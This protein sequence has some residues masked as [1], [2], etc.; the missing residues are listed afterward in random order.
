[1]NEETIKKLNIYIQL[2]L[3]EII[4]FTGFSCVLSMFGLKLF[5][6]ITCLFYGLL[7]VSNFMIKKQIFTFNFYHISQEFLLIIAPV[8]LV[9]LVE[10]NFMITTFKSN[11]GLK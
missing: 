8:I 7:A 3:E 10:L 11:N 1:M 2:Y 6:V 5:S 4:L 9:P